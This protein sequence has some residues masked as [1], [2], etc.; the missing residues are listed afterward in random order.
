MEVEFETITSFEVDGIMFNI[1]PNTNNHVEITS[2]EGG[3]TG[4]LNIPES[5]IFQGN[6][7]FVTSIGTS[8]FQNCKDLTGSLVIPN[9][10]TSIGN[11]AFDFCSGLTGLL[12]IPNSVISIGNYA[13]SRCSGLTGALA[14]PNSV[15]SIGEYAFWGCSG[16][17]G[18]LTIPN[19]V[20][21]INVYTF[22]GCSGLTGPLTIPNSVISIGSYAFSGCSG[23]TGPLTIPSGVINIGGMAFYDCSGFTGP[24]TIPSSINSIG[25][26]AFSNCSSLTGSLTIPGSIKIIKSGTFNGCSGLTGSLT[27]P[28]SVTTIEHHAFN[29]CSGLTGPLTFPNSITSIGESAFYGCNQIAKVVSE[30]ENPFSIDNS[31][32]YTTTEKHNELI[33]PKGTKPKY[34]PLIGWTQYFNTIIEDSNNYTLSIKAIGYG[35]ATYNSTDVRNTTKEFTVV[36]GTS[37]T[38]TLTPDNGYKIKSMKKDGTDI[39]SSVTNSQYTIGNIQGNTTVEV[40]F[41]SRP[42]A[43]A[44]QGINY[45]VVSFTDNTLR[46]TK[47]DYGQVLEVPSTIDY[48]GEQWR[49]SGI[50]NDALTACTTLAAVIWHPEA[51]FT[52]TVSN[53]N[54]LLYVSQA[55]LAPAAITN[56]VADGVAER[57]VLTDAYSGNSFYCP[58]AFTARSISYSHRYSM[59][60]GIGEARGWETLALPFDVQQVTHETKGEIVPFTLWHSGDDTKPFWLMT[61]TSSGWKAA[62][63][64]KADTPYIIS[65]PN[66]AEYKE[67]FL[68]NGKVTFSAENVSIKKT[69]DMQTA[70]YN[71]RTFIPTYAEQK[72]SSGIFALNVS[73]DYDT[74]NS[75]MEDGSHFVLNLRTVHPFEAY[76]TTST[77]GTR[78]IDISEGMDSAIVEGEQIPISVYN[79]KGQMMKTDAGKTI[80]EIRKVLPAGVYII[81]GHKMIVK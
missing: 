64:I 37:A 22:C 15:T 80:E 36:E 25:Y 26:C 34:E 58:Q 31:V 11:C 29:G 7:Y 32:F 76:M 68:L 65:M 51:A 1:I 16:F 71:D 19:S 74:N 41:D 4:T 13:F 33:I 2:K 66:N 44:Y 39:T 50:E 49:V 69:E 8:A 52:A 47:G 27:I 61:L 40:E 9:T 63:R 73:N 75:G 43:I 67:E 30:I 59:T 20:T 53:P 60:T 78:A 45:H 5:V 12:S 42:S 79:L 28:N 48:E 38:I 77:R 21:S 54:L 24:L 57:I 46:V 17:N 6:T 14:I 35:S 23:L 62:E 55:D 72:I 10:V 70:S 56:V 3:Y 18:S 81:N